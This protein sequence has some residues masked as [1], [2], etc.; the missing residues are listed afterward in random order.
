MT[1]IVR[2]K[3]KPLLAVVTLL[4]LSGCGFVFGPGYGSADKHYFSEPPMVVKKDSRYLLRWRYGSMGFYFYPRYEVRNGSLVFSLQG[5]SSSG[6][7]AGKVEEF[8]IE[9][10]EAIEALKKGGAFWWEPD[11]SLTPLAIKEE[12]NPP[13]QHNTGSRPCSS[14]SSSLAADRI[15]QMPTPFPETIVGS[16][17]V[18]YRHR[19]DVVFM[20][21]K[22]RGRRRGLFER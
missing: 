4:A 3:M 20:H 2:R 18:L 12:A 22:A 19:K 7:R 17:Y 14:D 21:E 6:S 13:P 5:T 16:L 8:P 9:G 11:G 1:S 10:I 15:E